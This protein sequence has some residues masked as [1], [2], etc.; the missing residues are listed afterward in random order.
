M[1]TLCV[2]PVFNEDNRLINLIDQIKSYEYKNYNLTYIFVNNG[3]TDQSLNIIKRSNIK[4]LNLKSNKGVGYALMIGYLYAKKYNFK[5]LI[6][7]AGNGK[8]KPSQIEVFMQH[9]L[10]KN[11]DFVT[12]S[13]FLDGSS[14]KNNPI[15]RIILIKTFSFFLKIFLKKNISDPSCGFRAF[16]I[17]I[18]SNFK[19]EYFKKKELFTYGYEYYSLG[20]VINSKDINFIEIPV[21]MDYPT[22]GKYSKIRPI[23]DWYIIAKFWIKGILSK[24][25]L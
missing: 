11:Y 9:L 25:K 5:Y 14:K 10:I 6:H 17:N 8:M 12:G 24:N 23:I 2:I 21:S 22:T 4:Y 19:K 15:I 20:K 1:K 16:D 13:R 3:S 7:L 18:F